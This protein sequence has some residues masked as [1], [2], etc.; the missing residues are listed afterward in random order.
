[1]S[2]SKSGPGAAGVR[3]VEL[4]AAV[5]DPLAS[6]TLEGDVARRH[7]V[8]PMSF[9]GDRLILAMVDP[10]DAEALN[11]VAALTGTIVEPVLATKAQIAKAILAVYGDGAA[12]ASTQKGSG[13]VGLD[14]GD[15]PMLDL[16]EVLEMVL[17]N[18]ASDLHL[19]NGLPPT[20]RIDGELMPIE[21]YAPLEPEELQRVA[22]GMLTQKQREQFEENLE[23]DFS[24]SLPGKARFRVNLYQQR[25]AVGAAFR[26]VP[27]AI[28]SV[29]DLGLP[30]IIEQFARIPRGLV[31]V[32]GPTGSGKSTTLAALVDVINRERPVH[33]MTIE[34]PIEFL[35]P[36]R[37]AVVNQREVGADTHA[38]ANALKHVLRQDPDVILVGE[39]RDIETMQMAVTAAETGHLVFAT[40]HTQDAAQTVDRIIDAFPPGQQQQ[41]RVQLALSL[42]GVVA[43]QLLPLANGAG[44]AV[45]AE[46]MMVTPA[47]RNLIREGKTH[48]LYSVM[49]AGAQFGMQTMDAALAALVNEGVVTFEAAKERCHNAD[50]F[51]RLAGARGSVRSI[52]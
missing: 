14:L 51:V 4:N 47:V 22:Y 36:H 25:G 9:E 20:L 28:R 45:A 35:H 15:K 6:A 38:F 10:E 39:M 49:Q 40:L 16:H 11:D 32:T 50:E 18:D 44:R 1:M 29:D 31:V 52:G 48:Q 19:T 8:M 27:F 12:D 43:Q 23:L 17:E 7:L 33:I 30:D 26:L 21:G 46:I 41:I 42:Q 37:M 3:K 24:Y 5:L 2:S 34:D 13:R